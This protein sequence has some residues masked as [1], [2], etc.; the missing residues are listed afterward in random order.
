MRHVAPDDAAGAQHGFRPGEAAGEAQEA[1]A[2][3]GKSPNRGK[4]IDV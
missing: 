1:D 4:I 3:A 2:G